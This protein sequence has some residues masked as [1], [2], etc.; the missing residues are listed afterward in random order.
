M[1]VIF[2]PKNNISDKILRIFWSPNKIYVK[3]FL[4][5]I[6]DAKLN[7]CQI[8]LTYVSGRQTA[9][10]GKA[11]PGNF[12]RKA[13]SGTPAPRDLASYL[14][15]PRRLTSRA[16][17]ITC[18]HQAVTHAGWGS[19]RGAPESPD[20]EKYNQRASDLN[21]SRILLKIHGSRHPQTPSSL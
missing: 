17:L 7:I 15:T 2:L 14:Q 18:G 13:F 9:I 19:C 4:T 6:V 1:V 8:F 20:P 12:L 3:I 21:A 5:Y 16:S 10:G 11:S